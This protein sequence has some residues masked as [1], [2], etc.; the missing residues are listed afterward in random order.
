MG[1]NRCFAE[2]R[3]RWLFSVASDI[4]LG[5]A[6]VNDCAH[7]L[8]TEPQLGLI[9][10]HCTMQRTLAGWPDRP[11]SAARRCASE[12]GRARRTQRP[13]ARRGSRDERSTRLR[14]A[15]VAVPLQHGV[16]R[17]PPGSATR[18][19]GS[20]TSTVTTGPT[21]FSTTR[22]SIRG[23]T[24]RRSRRSSGTTI[25]FTKSSTATR[26]SRIAAATRTR[27]RFREL[28][29]YLAFLEAASAAAS[30]SCCIRSRGDCLMARRSCTSGS[31][32][33][34]G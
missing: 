9:G 5:P 7:R 2:A 1:V 15:E 21:T 10:W 17:H 13:V 31:G 28:E 23:S 25:T 24:S 8:E 29:H 6:I 11:L 19:A 20:R 12:H 16:F 33:G 22:C 32:A 18:S 30:V 27:S 14:R 26:T 34:R 4:A 3:G